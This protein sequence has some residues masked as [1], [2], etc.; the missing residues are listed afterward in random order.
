MNWINK[1]FHEVTPI[2]SPNPQVG[3]FWTLKDSRVCVIAKCEGSFAAV[4]QSKQGKK[5]ILEVITDK[6][7]LYETLSSTRATL[8]SRLEFVKFY[9]ALEYQLSEVRKISVKE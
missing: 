5:Y 2:D 4:A 8:V 1:E 9:H 6:N 7:E 3:E